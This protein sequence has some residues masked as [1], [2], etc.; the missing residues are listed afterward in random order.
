MQL[1]SY[2]C[3]GAIALISLI[4]G[5]I[6]L[7]RGQFMPY[8]RVALGKS[9]QE[10]EADTQTLILALMRATGGGLI[11]TAIAI[12]VLLY[13]P[14]RAGEIWASYSIFFVSLGSSC[15]SCYAT[16]LVKQKTP[17]NPPLGLSIATFFL[18]F[19]GLINFLLL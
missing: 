4:F 3:Y 19:I 11:S 14:V 5:L 6:Y 8:H 15:G 16:F 10:I 9:W 12:L 1:I 7:I 2:F 18:S 17:G 13:I